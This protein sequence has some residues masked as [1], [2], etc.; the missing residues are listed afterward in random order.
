MAINENKLVKL[1]EGRHSLYPDPMIL[2]TIEK[3]YTWVLVAI[4]LVNLMQRKIPNS[5]KKRF[6]TIYIA[7][8]LL[9]FQVG[10]VT[11]LAR[12]LDHKWGILVLAVCVGLLV[13]FR[14][15]VL[16][17][18][19]TCAKCNT[20]LDMNHIIGHDDNLCQKCYYEEHPEEAPQEPAIEVVPDAV[21]QSEANLVSD[22]DWDL[23]DP[24]EVCVITYLFDGDKVLLI[25]KKTGLGKGLVNAPGGHIEEAETA[26]EAAIREFK[27]ETDLTITDLKMV[28]KL[29]FQFKDGL[30]ERGYVYF[31][32]KH[33]G[34]AKETEEAKPFWCPVSEIPYDK[35][36][37]DDLYWLPLALEG[38]HFEGFFIF[39]DQKMLDKNVVVEDD[40]QE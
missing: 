8:I 4:L 37:E 27:E 34:D 26:L 33:T 28:G 36:W 11:I 18:K 38:K 16:P 13:I 21:T 19:L 17:F 5:T 6:A 31:A 15:R 9:V 10:I 35:M 25:D 30:S 2:E 23:W 3:N 14:K 32:T 29:N 7:S 1:D 24:K 22:I 40:E 20:R 39:D 12:N